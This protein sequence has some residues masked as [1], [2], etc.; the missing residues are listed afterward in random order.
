M[1]DDEHPPEALGAENEA[2]RRRVAA[3]ED[4]LAQRDR[5]LQA[6]VDHVPGLVYVRETEAWTI[7]LIN[8]VGA[9]FLGGRPEEIVGRPEAD[10]FP[11]ETVAAWRANDLR[12]V[13]AGEPIEQE[14]TAPHHDGVHTHRSVKFPIRDGQG[15]V[16]A[17]GGI[18]VDITAQRRA[19]QRLLE[20][21]RAAI[22]ELSTPVIPIFEGTL[23]VPLVGELDP[24][25]VAMLGEKVPAAI[26][27]READLVILD[28]TG[29]VGAVDARAIEGLIRIARAARLL[30]AQVVITGFGPRSSRAIVELGTEILEEIVSIGT[31]QDGVAYALRRRG[32]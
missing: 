23:V 14:E 12:I 10:F 16:C 9:G 13:A 7:T 27:S 21:H 8:R 22:Q 18:S 2:L 28:V 11:P 4:A 24:V 3:L 17:V 20:A 29:V 26:V 32:R 15:A 5:L 31:L 1:A 6:I 25:R 19:E 30:G